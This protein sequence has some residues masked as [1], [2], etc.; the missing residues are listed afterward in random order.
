MIKI[1]RI[2]HKLILLPLIQRDYHLREIGEKPDKWYWADYLAGCV[3]FFHWQAYRNHHDSWYLYPGKKFFKDE[4]FFE[5]HIRSL[6]I[7]DWLGIL[8]TTLRV[9]RKSLLHN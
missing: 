8:K 5:N 7:K 1:I 6:S 2:F 9:W 4:V 3:G